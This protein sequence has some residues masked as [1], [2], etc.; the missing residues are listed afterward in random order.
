MH[1]F[2][3]A[4]MS[5]SWRKEW[6]IVELRSVIWLIVLGLLFSCRGQVNFYFACPCIYLQESDIASFLLTHR[7]EKKIQLVSSASFQSTFYIEQLAVVVVMHNKD[8]IIMQI[9]NYV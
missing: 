1:I 8:D 2:L 4:C 5:Y 7:G 6:N 9:M 3:A